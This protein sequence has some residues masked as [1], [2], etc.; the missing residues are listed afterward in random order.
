M[1]DMRI[2]AIFRATGKRPLRKWRCWTCEMYKRDPPSAE[3]SR[4]TPTQLGELLSVDA[5]GPFSTPALGT[6]WTHI[7]GAHDVGGDI[8][9]DIGSREPTGKICANFIDEICAIY[10]TFYK[11]PECRSSCSRMA[12]HSRPRRSLMCL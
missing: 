12:R 6:G 11:K 10:A 7:I 2:K 3:E 4:N 9:D 5:F 8:V 1:C